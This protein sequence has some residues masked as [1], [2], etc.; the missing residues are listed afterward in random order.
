MNCINARQRIDDL[1]DGELDAGAESRLRAHLDAC[2]ACERHERSLRGLLEQARALPEEIEPPRDL[3]AGIESRLDGTRA[4]SNPRAAAR[5]PGWPA[6]LAAAAIFIVALTAAYLAGRGSVNRVAPE[7]GTR[8]EI[9]PPVAVQSVEPAS[10]AGVHGEQAFLEAKRHLCAALE[11]R[12]AGWSAETAATIDRNL[13]IIEQ[14]TAE[15]T[16]ALR[17]DPSNRELNRLL[18]AQY[19][20]EIGY[21]QRMVRL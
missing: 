12:R 13:E 20:R 1:L 16:A 3:W 8:A 15:I 11:V 4:E 18:L 14:A 6:L 17:K 10:G 5:R 7:D 9:R 2:A 19:Q 21:M